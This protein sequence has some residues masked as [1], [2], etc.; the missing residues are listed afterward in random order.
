MGRVCAQGMSLILGH[1]PPSWILEPPR[2]VDPFGTFPCWK[3]H[4]SPKGSAK[5]GREGRGEAVIDGRQLW[6]IDKP[7]IM[8]IC[9]ICPSP[10]CYRH[11]ESVSIPKVALV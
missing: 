3:A 1:E 11:L 5:R 4:L 10:L 2:S 9:F 7:F 6:E 8:D